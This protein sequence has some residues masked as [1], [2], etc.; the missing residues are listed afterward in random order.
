MKWLRF[1]VLALADD[2]LDG[3]NQGVQPLIRLATALVRLPLPFI[4]NPHGFTNLSYLLRLNLRDGE[5]RGYA[6][7]IPY[8]Y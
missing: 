2:S 3:V 7:R 4:H 6:I 8:L 1:P 5:Q